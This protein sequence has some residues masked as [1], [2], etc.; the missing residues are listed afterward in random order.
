ML[1][2]ILRALTHKDML[3]EM[4]EQ[5]GK[6]LDAGK[7]MFE[8]ASTALMREIDWSAIA[9]DLYAR[10]RQIN[11]MEQKIREQIVTHMSQ[12]NL[13]DL[14]ACLILMSV[15]KDAERIGD[16]DKNIFEIAKFYRREFAHPEYVVPLDDI[17]TEVLRMFDQTRDAFVEPN[18]KLARKVIDEASKARGRCDVLV[19][20]LLAVHDSIAADEAVAYVLCARFY[21]R[22]AAHLANIATS[23]VSPVPMIDYGGKMPKDEEETD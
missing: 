3:V 14:S 9:D 5:F 16:Y 6:M 19:R 1:M 7:E 2:D 18:N 10:D 4:I 21:K 8:Q 12:G 22:V 17:R 13:P 20:Q 11:E 23:V 15:V